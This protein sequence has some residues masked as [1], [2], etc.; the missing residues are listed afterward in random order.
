MRNHHP[1][2]LVGWYD[3]WRRD[4]CHDTGRMVLGNF[5]ERIAH[6]FIGR[7]QFFNRLFNRR[8]EILLSVTSHLGVH[9]V[10][11]ATVKREG[12]GM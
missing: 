6:L 11:F 2:L 12:E 5:Q 3:K 4:G 10:A 7:L 1:L 9:A 8:N